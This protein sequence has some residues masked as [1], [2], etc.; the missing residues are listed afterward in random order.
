MPSHLKI[1]PIDSKAYLF[2]IIPCG[3]LGTM[4]HEKRVKQ[5]RSF[6][7]CYLSGEAVLYKIAPAI[8]FPYKQN[9][10]AMYS[11]FNPISYG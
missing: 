1:V 10:A 3:L 5:E 2:N 9:L 11:A 6:M 7:F 4:K 8:L